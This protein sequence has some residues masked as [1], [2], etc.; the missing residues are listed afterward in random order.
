MRSKIV[1]S[2]L[3]A[4][5]V[6]AVL[7]GVGCKEKPPAEDEGAAAQDEVAMAF[8]Y[9]G[10]NRVGWSEKTD[11][12]TG[13]PA[14]LPPSTANKPQL[15]QTFKD[16][17]NELAHKPEYLFLCGDIVRNE[18]PGFKTLEEQLDLWQADWASGA[19]AGSKSTMLVPFPGN[20]EVLKSVEY[21]DGMYYEVP[22]PAAYGT[23]V[24]WLNKN[25][26]FPQKG[27]GPAAGGGDLLIG[28]NSQQSYSFDA[29][30]ADG[31]HAHFVVLN[32]D[33][34]SSFKCDD[35]MCYQPPQ[36]DVQFKGATIEGTMT[37][38]MPGWIAADWAVKDIA[39]AAADENT[40]VI[41]VLGHKP[42]LN[43]EEKS[44]QASTG[45]DT[46]FNCDEGKLGSRLFAALQSAQ[47][48]GKFGGYLCAHQHL[49]DAFQMPGAE[50]P[51]LW[52]VI[53]GNGGTKLNAGDQFGFTYVQIYKSGKV[54]ATS[55]GRKVPESYYYAPTSVAATP[56]KVILLREGK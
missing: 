30:T 17:A 34:H 23:W 50:G 7:F 29:P 54:T 19:L 44:D 3:F 22:S 13:K 2:R 43:R 33:S 28:D 41:F 55:Y 27:N 48:A 26:H 9:V 42:L 32:T 31:K 24:N 5:G 21:A 18:Q 4:A 39:A 52:Q 20:H 37:Q 56:G 6:L 36:Q 49:W 12:A 1:G 38:G 10:C 35:P 40:D 14:P 45:R 8:V 53:A 15:M 16:V 11:P 51:K 46:I 25:K 47:E